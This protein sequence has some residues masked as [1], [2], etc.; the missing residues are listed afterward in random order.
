MVIAK[1]A[2]AKKSSGTREEYMK[3]IKKQK[4]QADSVLDS[5]YS[6]LL[7]PDVTKE[8][9]LRHLQKAS[10]AGSFLLGNLL[11]KITE[12][13]LNGKEI[14]SR[15][16]S[17]VL[18][19]LKSLEYSPRNEIFDEYSESKGEQTFS[20]IGSPI[21]S[22]VINMAVRKLKQECPNLSE[23]FKILDKLDLREYD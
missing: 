14:N 18:E 6:K 4:K 5:A 2:A 8:A 21:R 10:D 23:L 7:S 22:C 9:V 11:I 19:I 20:S 3:R 16:Y 15:Q 17:K 1:K 13:F 12:N